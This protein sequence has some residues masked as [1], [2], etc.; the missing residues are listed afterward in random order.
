MAIPMF[1]AVVSALKWL[2]P[3]IL[4]GAKFLGR[5]VAQGASKALSVTTKA[6]S[7]GIL[8]TGVKLASTTKRPF[9]NASILTLTKLASSEKV[10]KPLIKDLTFKVA[11]Q[12][13][14]PIPVIGSPGYRILDTL[15]VI[16]GVP[17]I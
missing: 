7:K 16:I 11:K 10:L 8:K 1:S 9:V 6:V 4:S 15:D 13:V 12:I 14:K 5:H 17:F 3:K 2:A